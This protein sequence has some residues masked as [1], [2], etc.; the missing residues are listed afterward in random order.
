[1]TGVEIAAIITSISTLIAA[2]GTLFI[3]IL[4]QRKINEVKV[5]TDGMSHRLEAA[6]KQ[7]GLIQ[8]RE[9]TKLTEKQVEYAVEKVISKLPIK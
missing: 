6:A 5:S 4:N 9:E 3:A 2:I 7:A 1:M 8:G